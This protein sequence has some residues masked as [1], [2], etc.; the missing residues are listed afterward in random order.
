[1]SPTRV[2]PEGPAAGEFIRGADVVAKAGDDVTLFGGV[3]ADGA[4]I[5]CAVE[6]LHSTS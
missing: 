6:T 2:S 3:G 4:L 1:M 5:V